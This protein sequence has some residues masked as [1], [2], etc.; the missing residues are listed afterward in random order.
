MLD[1]D[2]VWYL[3]LIPYSLSLLAAG[4]GLGFIRGKKHD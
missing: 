4:Y 3:L 2:L 1:S